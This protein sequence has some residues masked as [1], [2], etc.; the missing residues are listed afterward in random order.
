MLI[1]RG[2]TVTHTWSNKLQYPCFVQMKMIREKLGDKAR[3]PLSQ[4]MWGVMHGRSWQKYDCIVGITM[5]KKKL[6]WCQVNSCKRLSP[7]HFT[8]SAF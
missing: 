4:I 2:T 8:T 5:T 3:L 6:K 1:S 7:L